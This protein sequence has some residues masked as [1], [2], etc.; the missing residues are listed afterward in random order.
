MAQLTYPETITKGASGDPARLDSGN[1]GSRF[2]AEG[3]DDIAFGR[4]VETDGA[5]GDSNVKL[6]SGGKL[7]GVALRDRAKSDITDG[8]VGPVELAVMASGEVWVE[9]DGD[10]TPSDDVF[11]REA[12][13][14]EVFTI[15]F[16]IDFVALNVINGTVAGSAI[17]P[18]TFAVDHATT[19]AALAAAIQLLENVAT[20]AVTGARE[21]TVTGA[22]GG[23]DLSST[24]TNFTVTLGASQ[25][26]DTIANVT[27]PS[28]SGNLGVFRADDDDVGSG[29]LAVQVT[30][31]KFRT[32]ADAGGVALLDINLP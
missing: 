32:S 10:V 3:E 4:G 12:V 30:R 27:G 1:V 23:E 26:V 24:G 28:S 14:V 20:A 22:T 16:D 9:V 13:E 11:I 21:I 8:I 31:A 18:V 5:N 29:A 15:T 25:A 17:A 19:L 7:V 2:L 6:F